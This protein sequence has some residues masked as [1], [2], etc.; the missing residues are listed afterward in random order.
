MGY[1]PLSLK[2]ALSGGQH[3]SVEVET[4]YPFSVSRGPGAA[5]LGATWRSEESS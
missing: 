2:A 4:D 1:A 5:A 3:V